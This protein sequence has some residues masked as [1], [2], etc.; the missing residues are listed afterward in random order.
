MNCSACQAVIPD[1]SEFCPECGAR[2]AAPQP[3]ASAPD[4]APARA[5]EAAAPKSGLRNLVVVG[6]ALIV[7]FIGVQLC[8]GSDEEYEGTAY[9]DT[10]ADPEPSEADPEP[11]EVAEGGDGTL[12]FSDDFSAPGRGWWVGDDTG[13]S[14][15][16]MRQIADGTYFMSLTAKGDQGNFIA[17]NV[18]VD[19]STLADFAL[20]FR[21]E[22]ADFRGSAPPYYI[23][24]LGITEGFAAVSLSVSATH[25]RV[26]YWDSDGW[27]PIVEWR[28][29]KSGNQ[30]IDRLRVSVRGAGLTLSVN[31]QLAGVAFHPKIHERGGIALG[32]AVSAKGEFARFAFDDVTLTKF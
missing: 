9:Q 14:Y 7:V 15:D 11:S 12:F 16:G 22:I 29:L 3:A 4:A 8:S 26:A 6:A 27:Q 19:G 30:K 21:T 2:L 28:P 1:D 13:A 32:G 24:N 23:V 17:A 31:D 5:G 18:P 10:E 25:Y 20:D